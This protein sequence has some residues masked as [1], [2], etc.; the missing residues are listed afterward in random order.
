MEKESFIKD[1]MGR[2]TYDEF[3][4]IAK[5]CVPPATIIL[6]TVIVLTHFFHWKF[7]SLVLNFITGTSLIFLAYIIGVVLLLDFG[8]DVWHE[9]SRDGSDRIL[10]TIFGGYKITVV[11][12]V[13]LVVLA[14]AAVY[15]SNKYRNH[16]SFE[17][18]TFLV[19][20]QK[21][22]Y[23][24]KGYNT[25]CEEIEDRTRLVRMQGYE[26]E[27]NNYTYCISC[28]EWEGEAMSDIY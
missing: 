20:E 2:N 25:D 1:I 13:L 15:Y 10:R 24:L 11:W 19:D 26:I 3:K 4:G 9:Q 17:C 28:E 6:V 14:I 27:E 22:I 23:H 7:L 8:V 5:L 21:G 18:A 12:A 16:Y